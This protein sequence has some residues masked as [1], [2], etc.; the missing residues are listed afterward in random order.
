MFIPMKKCKTCQTPIE[1]PSYCT[2]CKAE[3]QRKWQ[4]AHPGYQTEA[5]KRWMAKNKERAL[6]RER[7]RY[8]LRFG[9]IQRGPCEVCGTTEKVEGHHED[10]TRPLD[11][12]WLCKE[13]HRQAHL[14]CRA[15]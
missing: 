12:R 15:V 2:T 10:Y 4:L 9:K 13:H 7:Y 14:E 5:K 8:A 3:Y 11:V 6:S 1:K